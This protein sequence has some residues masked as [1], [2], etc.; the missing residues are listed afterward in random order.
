MV[1]FLI[2]KHPVFF[3]K[4]VVFNKRKLQREIKNTLH[5]MK[6]VQNCSFSPRC[7]IFLRSSCIII[8]R[9][10]SKRCHWGLRNLSAIS[11]VYP[12]PLVHFFLTSPSVYPCISLLSRHSLIELSEFK[13]HFYLFISCSRWKEI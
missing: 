11:V 5:K 2:F 7:T 12:N 6:T 10:P 8:I 9:E 4:I 3:R 13:G 1:I